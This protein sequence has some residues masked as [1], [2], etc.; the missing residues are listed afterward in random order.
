MSGARAVI[1]DMD[2]VIVDSEPRHERAFLEVVS[3]L[4]YGHNHGVELS[5]Y[6]G[7]TDRE[8]WVDFVQR[9][10]PPHTL[11]ALLA[12]KRERV[13][14]ILRK[15]QPLFEGLPELV[16]RLAGRYKLGLASGSEPL[17]VQEVL[18][19]RGL[20]QFFSAVT[21]SSEVKHGKPAPDIF[22]RAAKLL[23]VH[24]EECW[25]IEDSK[26]GVAAGLAA[27]MRV[28]AITN[29]HPAAELGNATRV[30]S[31]YPEIATILL[32]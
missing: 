20:R 26:P 23:E 5:K 24:P 6:I 1:F 7:K 17:V 30:V 2:G 19:F 14:E 25:V 16:E 29:T 22:L 18:T 15:E 10:Q 4:G 13:L 27:G 31:S 32:G 21:T 9:H 8:V 3:G 12:M 28:I 11:E